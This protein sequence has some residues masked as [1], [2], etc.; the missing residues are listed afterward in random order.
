MPEPHRRPRGTVKGQPTIFATVSTE[1]K[2][3]LANIAA[4]Q[5]TSQAW[6]LDAILTSL[7]SARTIT[8][9]LLGPNN[10]P[11][12][13]PDTPP[14]PIELLERVAEGLTKLGETGTFIAAALADHLETAQPPSIE[15]LPKAE[16]E[17]L[18]ES[19]AFSKEEL[20][21]AEEAVKR[22]ELQW[23]EMRG[24]LAHSYK[25]LS[26]SA[27]ADR[28]NVT[29]EELRATVIARQTHAHEIGGELRFPT[30]QF[31]AKQP[32]GLVRGLAR[33]LGSVSAADAELLD[34]LMLAPQDELPQCTSLSPLSWLQGDGDVG[35]V[36]DLIKD[37]ASS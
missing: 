36:V 24:F 3:S 2:R 1:A 27:A 16:A 10:N 20:V 30:W 19:G 35:V 12:P 8:A 15:I 29:E 22:G 28:L 32:D 14:L 33:I 34:A 11:D 17:W 25:T 37:Q 4:A 5:H 18:L 26:L 23:L 6:S 9:S 7:Q 31:D 13:T 21:S